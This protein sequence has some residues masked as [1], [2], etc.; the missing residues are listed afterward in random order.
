MFSFPFG[1][2]CGDKKKSNLFFYMYV[3][4]CI[5]ELVAIE[6]NSL[7]NMNFFFL[8][9][10]RNNLLTILNYILNFRI[11]KHS[12]FISYR[13]LL[14]HHNVKLN[15][16][17]MH[18]FHSYFSILPPENWG[19]RLNYERLWIDWFVYSSKFSFIHTHEHL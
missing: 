11:W 19:K 15:P 8:N 2:K 4:V 16:K 17:H 10:R 9:H 12:I 5:V 14:L 13:S 18:L 3:R 1:F 6:F 7:N